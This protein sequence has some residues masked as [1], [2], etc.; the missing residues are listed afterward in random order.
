MNYLWS[1]NIEKSF[2]AN[3]Y[4]GIF[5]WDM[6]KAF[7]KQ[8]ASEKEIGDKF[9]E[10][11]DQ[12]LNENV[13][14]EDIE[15]KGM[16]PARY[17]KLITEEGF[18]RLQLPKEYGGHELSH[19]N[20]FRI[21]QTAI[22]NCFPAGFTLATHNAFG[23]GSIL[24]AL[25]EGYL[26]D[27]ISEEL[28]NGG[29]SG[30]ADTEPTGAAN[31]LVS[32]TAT[33][34]EDGEHYIIN[35][36]K[37]YIA[38]G[39]IADILIV[40][41]TVTKEDGTDEGCLFIVD[42]KNQGFSVDKVHDLMG[43]RGFPIAALNFN[44]VKV[45]KNKMVSMKEGHW[46]D[47]FLLEPISALGRMFSLTSA[48]LAVSKKCLTWM[49][50]FCNRKKING[51]SLGEYEEIQRKISQTAAEIFAME[52]VI[53]WGI[54]NIDFEN[55]ADRWW[56][57]FSTKNITTL[58]ANHIAD[59][60][61]AVFGA[62]GYEKAQSKKEIGYSAIE[63]EQ[64]FRDIRGLRISGGVDFQ[65]DNRSTQLWLEAFY[66]N[67]DF[68][69][70][71]VKNNFGIAE[72]IV[73]EA[74]NLSSLNKEHLIKVND[75]VV[76]LGNHIKYL[77]KSF[78]KEELFAKQRIMILTNKIVREI[79]L[80]S[81]CLSRTNAANKELA[82]DYN[83]LTETYCIDSLQKIQSYWHQLDCELQQENKNPFN[84]LGNRILDGDLDTIVLENI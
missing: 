8:S 43:L 33:L 68:D 5:K 66:Y 60:T 84:I 21:L 61:I 74:Q 65:I 44:N 3:V 14:K 31:R 69:I 7:P 62:E 55:L 81:C 15:D 53:K 42:T 56:E 46:R 1:K 11:I 54:I 58:F 57:L 12:I 19:Y 73:K 41:T 77:V 72:E 48:S 36:R 39:S 52:S 83:M 80:I 9:C 79:Y 70:D 78:D 20:T 16:L 25:P 82:N 35:G 47:T 50:D 27:Y 32:T 18:T 6:V 4:L 2:L 30:W 34:C 13:K 37:V 23:A 63:L 17:L 24:S 38:N 67:S 40:S 10:R 64:V 51:I 45:H 75:E 26:K 76:K 28:R 22:R 29:F 49:K 59:R 71:V